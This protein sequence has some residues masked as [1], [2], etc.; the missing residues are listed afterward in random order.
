MYARTLPFLIIEGAVTTTTAS[1]LLTSTV[2]FEVVR[3]E[4]SS[5]QKAP[6]DSG[7]DFRDSFLLFCL[8]LGFGIHGGAGF[9]SGLRFRGLGLGDSCW[10]W[11][12]RLRCLCQGPADGLACPEPY[13]KQP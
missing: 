7:R 13:T 4:F 5:D 10:L 9:R 11:L 12:G 3:S 8:G 6:K 2:G 1:A